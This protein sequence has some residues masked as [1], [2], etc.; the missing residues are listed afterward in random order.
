LATLEFPIDVSAEELV[1]DHTFLS[2]ADRSPQAEDLGDVVL[3]NGAWAGVCVMALAGLAAGGA[4][5][6][7]TAI[8]AMLA[9]LVPA[10]GTAIWLRARDDAGARGALL[11]L[12]AVCSAAAAMLTGGVSGPLAVWCLAPVVAA[13]VFGASNLLA[14]AGAL[15]LAAAAVTALAG[16]AG[17]LP[18]EPTG[19]A[20][21]WL[22][23]VGIVTTGLGLG[24]GLLLARRRAAARE[25]ALRAA[26]VGL[27]RLL[28]EQPH[29]VMGLDRDGRVLA[30]FGYAPLGIDGAGLKG[31]NLTDMAGAAERPALRAA[32]AAALTSGWS[33]SIFAPVGQPERSCALSLRRGADGKLAAVVRDSTPEAVHVAQLERAREDAESLNAGKSRFLANMSHELRTPL[34]AVIGFSD[35][36][37]QGLFGQ[38]QPRYAEYADMIHDAGRHLLELI[39]DVL[40]LSK[41]EAA[42]YELNREPID[43]RDPVSAALRLTRLQADESRVS[44]RGL[45]PEAPLPAMA[46]PR[47]IKQIVLN[48]VSNALK[49]TPAGG[50]VTVSANGYGE[51]LEIVVSDTGVG[52]AEADL[53][54]IG[55]PYEQ[56]GDAAQKVRGTGLGLSLVQAFA[57]LHGGAMSI[58]SRLGEGTSVTVRM[59]VLQ[60]ESQQEAPAGAEIIAFDPAR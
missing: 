43:A 53:A 37:R 16:L 10:V 14:S 52:I 17:L 56:A 39:N 24:A 27:E 47:A 34:N 57:E 5:S 32:I 13:S 2:A 8:L 26:E 28:A 49:F 21:F 6:S 9:G 3:W 7:A 30:A 48:L 50:S 15:S 51:D 38:L 40:D 1:A 36:M 29:L 58:E 12:W 19:A 4:A 33:D 54:R 60:T 18:P 11:A 46:D 59:P 44:L 25:Q 41:I 22:G 45:L 42:R 20:R 55:R 23:L 35:V 31:S